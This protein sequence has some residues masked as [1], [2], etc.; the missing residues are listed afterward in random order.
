MLKSEVKEKKTAIVKEYPRL[1][2]SIGSGSVYLMTDDLCGTR[3]SVGKESYRGDNIGHA[4][5]DLICNLED[6]EGEIILSNG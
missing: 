3:L 1:M 2:I 4:V 5:K 6:F